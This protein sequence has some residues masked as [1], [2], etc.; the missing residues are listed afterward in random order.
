MGR[1]RVF[2]TFQQGPFRFD[3]EN[4]PVGLVAVGADYRTTGLSLG[5]HPMALMR[6]HPMFKGCKRQ[7]DL[8][9]LNTNRFVRVA[10]LVT[11]RQRPGSAAG[12]V[13]LTL[14]DETGNINVVVWKDLQ[15][16]YRQALLG[17][18]LLLVKGVMECKNEVIHVIA[19]ELIDCSHVLDDLAVKSRD[20]H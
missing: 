5:T 10:G 8:A 15:Q 17:S 2:F 1:C 7:S 13:F 20:F 9:L 16:R 12:V 3:A 6:K 18:K 11:C 19:G 14:E 4:L